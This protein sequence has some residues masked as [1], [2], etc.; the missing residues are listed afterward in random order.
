ML[1]PEDRHVA[2][3][4]ICTTERCFVSAGRVSFFDI[5]VVMAT[6]G[7]SRKECLNYRG[8]LKFER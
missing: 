4:G 2:M 1:I 8:L 6:G 7:L 3:A 5:G